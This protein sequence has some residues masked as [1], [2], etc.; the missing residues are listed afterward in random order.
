[1]R[2][3]CNLSKGNWIKPKDKTVR[4]VNRK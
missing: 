1:M 3:N 2:E 4:W